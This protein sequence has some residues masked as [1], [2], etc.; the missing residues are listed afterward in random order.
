MITFACALRHFAIGK[1]NFSCIELE[2]LPYFQFINRLHIQ[3]GGE[4]FRKFFHSEPDLTAVHETVGGFHRQTVNHRA[5]TANVGI[6]DIRMNIVIHLHVQFNRRITLTINPV[7]TPADFVA[8]VHIVVFQHTPANP[9]GVF[10]NT[11]IDGMNVLCPINI[12]IVLAAFHYIDGD[13]MIE[14]YTAD[15]LDRQQLV[16]AKLGEVNRQGLVIAIPAIGL[17]AKAF[18]VPEIRPDVVVFQHN[19]VDE[20]NVRAVQHDNVVLIYRPVITRHADASGQI[21]A[22]FDHFHSDVMRQIQAALGGNGQTVGNAAGFTSHVVSVD[23]HATVIVIITVHEQRYRSFVFVADLLKR[24]MVVFAFCKLV[25]LHVE[26]ADPELGSHV[27]AHGIHILLGVHPRLAA[28]VRA[29]EDRYLLAD[30]VA[31]EAEGCLEGIFA[32][33]VEGYSKALI[34]PLEVFHFLQFRA[35]PVFR[36]QIGIFGHF[37]AFEAELFIGERNAFACADMIL[38]V[39]TRYRFRQIFGHVNHIYAVFIGVARTVFQRSSHFVIDGTSTGGI[40]GMDIQPAGILTVVDI[41]F[42]RQIAIVVEDFQLPMDLFILKQME[43]GLREQG[44]QFF[45]RRIALA[46]VVVDRVDLRDRTN[47]PV[48]QVA[49]IDGYRFS[50]QIVVE[51]LDSQETIDA[52]LMESDAETAVKIFPMGIF[53]IL[54]QYR[55]VPLGADFGAFGNGAIGKLHIL[56]PER[57][58][59]LHAFKV[60]ILLQAD[61]GGQIVGKFNQLNRELVRQFQT[62]VGGHGQAIGR[63]AGTVAEISGMHVD[64]AVI[65]IEIIDVNA[66]QIFVTVDLF[67]VPLV[68]LAVHQQIVLNV[69]TN[70]MNFF[71]HTR[72]SNLQRLIGIHPRAVG[73][74]AYENGDPLHQFNAVD[75]GNRMEEVAA[76]VKHGSKAMLIPLEGITELFDRI[77]PELE[78]DDIGFGGR[79]VLETDHIVV[80][81]QHIAGIQI[82]HAVAWHVDASRQ[83]IGRCGNLK[84]NLFIPDVTVFILYADAPGHAAGLTAEVVQVHAGA[85][86]IIPYIQVQVGKIF[87]ALQQFDIPIHLLSFKHI[88]VLQH[89]IAQPVADFGIGVGVLH[90]RCTIKAKLCFLNRTVAN[91]DPDLLVILNTVDVGKRTE[92]VAAILMQYGGETILVPLER[93]AELFDRIRPEVEVDNIRI[94]R[95][96]F[97]K[98]NHIVAGNQQLTGLQMNDAVSGHIDAG[99]QIIRAAGELE[100]KFFRPDEVFVVACNDAPGHAAALTAEV[101]Q[102]HAGAGHIMEDIQIQFGNTLIALNELHIPVQ[103][104]VVHHVVLIQPHMTQHIGAVGIGIDVLNQSQFVKLKRYVA[105]DNIHGRPQFHTIYIGNRLEQVAAFMQHG[106]KAVVIPLEG[107][108]VFLRRIGPEHEIDRSIFGHIAVEADHIIVGYQRI[109]GIQIGDVVIGHGHASGKA[110]RRFSDFKTDFLRPAVSFAG[111]QMDRPGHG[112]GFAAEVIQPCQCAFTTVIH[113]QIQAGKTRIAFQ[114]LDVPHQLFAGEY[115]VIFQ[116]GFD[117]PVAVVVFK[118]RDELDRREPVQTQTSLVQIAV[119]NSDPDLLDQFDAV[120]IGNRMEEVAAFLVQHRTEAVVIPF[121]GF[122]VVFHCIGPELEVDFRAFRH[123]AAHELNHVVA[124][125][126]DIAD[127]QIHYAVVR[128]GDTGG[129]VFGHLFDIDGMLNRPLSA[130]VRG[131]DKAVGHAAGFTG[132]VA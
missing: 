127:R 114:K 74:L 93:I 61:F 4:S 81:N 39:N 31:A 44:C 38:I 98:G 84:G 95:R 34:R 88:I 37:S 15:S 85:M 110:F 80:R 62:L 90:Q 14:L 94:R 73:S 28:S 91:D 11:G 21:I 102:H 23:I 1:G 72:I 36:T 45:N 99:G 57:E 5:G 63:A 8:R 12:G 30:A 22:A 103:L 113:I 9:G 51:A 43:M 111:S 125:I 107:I 42:S 68:V 70:R 124:R 122:A 19:A 3:L 96:A 126:Q 115:I 53:P 92:G 129:E 121:E 17:F 16:A 78:I 79:S 64:A 130:P 58:G 117:D 46:K 76:L 118:R 56:Y 86:T 10:F 104:F 119:A 108:A 2:G 89:C 106:G 65:I 116:I 123:F 131:G 32:F 112:A 20:R 69:S 6:A 100:G 109:A 49:H 54:K 24:P 55:I 18:K 105:H 27:S 67:K 128:H 47:H 29:N 83:V 52:F 120:D 59:F 50:E 25:I 66:H 40:A 87:V 7:K 97:F 41:Q 48:A 71:V 26:A 75:V 33:F 13:G 132:E 77:R 35:N 82:D 101:I 60:V